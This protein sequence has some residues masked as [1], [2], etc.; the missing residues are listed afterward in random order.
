MNDDDFRDYLRDWE[1]NDDNL[2]EVEGL[3]KFDAKYLKYLQE[4]WSIFRIEY[5]DEKKEEEV[6]E[7]VDELTGP[8]IPDHRRITKLTRIVHMKLNDF[9]KD[10]QWNVLY[11]DAH[12]YWYLYYKIDHLKKIL[13][14]SEIKED[15]PAVTALVLITPFAWGDV[16]LMLGCMA[17]LGYAAHLLITKKNPLF[18]ILA[19]DIIIFSVLTLCFFMFM[20]MSLLFY[21]FILLILLGTTDVVLGLTLFTKYN[22]KLSR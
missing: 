5:F 12:E 9:D 10:F 19:V 6:Y 22:K 18:T 8:D 7:Y 21:L 11:C 4:N 3:T 14:K 16:S 15:V 17:I 1:A 20:D 2:P 13:E